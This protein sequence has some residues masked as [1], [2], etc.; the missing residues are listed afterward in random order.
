MHKLTFKRF[1]HY[2]TLQTSIIVMAF[3]FLI[4]SKTIVFHT[5]LDS[6][7]K[8]EQE[9][10]GNDVCSPTRHTLERKAKQ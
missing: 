1:F 2:Q 7:M 8:K 3:D 10:V 9:V 4:C 6:D 5:R